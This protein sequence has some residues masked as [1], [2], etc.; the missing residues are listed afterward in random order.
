MGRTEKNR[1]CEGSIRINLIFA[2]LQISCRF[3]PRQ[4]VGWPSG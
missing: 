2:I 4:K 1:E 3:A